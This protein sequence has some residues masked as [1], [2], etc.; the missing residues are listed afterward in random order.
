MKTYINICERYGEPVPVT[1]D[2]YR[3]LNPT[4]QFVEV[5]DQIREYRIAKPYSVRIPECVAVLPSNYPPR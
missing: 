2:D 5:N 3:E 1:I 4:G